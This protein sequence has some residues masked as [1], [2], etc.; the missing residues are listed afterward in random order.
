MMVPGTSLPAII[1]EAV[2]Q[3]GP[4]F[5]AVVAWRSRTELGKW[6]GPGVGDGDCSNDT[7]NSEDGREMG[8]LGD[9]ASPVLAVRP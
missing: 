1:Y 2:S 8:R 4:D 3:V 5:I 7:R 9:A 6:I